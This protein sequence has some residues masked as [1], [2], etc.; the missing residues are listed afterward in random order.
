MKRLFAF[1]LAFITSNLIMSQ[2][3]RLIT[4]TYT[5]GDSKG[6]YVLKFNPKTAAITPLSVT[7]GVENPSYLAISKN[8]QFV[9]AVNENGGDK[10]GEVSAFS[11]NKKTGT[12][13]FINK[14][15]TSGDHPCYVSIDNSG[16]WVFAANYSGGNF[17][18][19]PVNADGSLGKA[20]QVVDDN[21]LNTDAKLKAHVHSTIFTPD[22]KFLL[23]PDLGL[24]KIFIYKFDATAAMPLSPADQ[25]F[26]SFTAGHGPRHVSFHPRLPF[27]Y[28]ISENSGTVSSYTYKDGKFKE[29]D[30]KSN[31]LKTTVPDYLVRKNTLEEWINRANQILSSKFSEGHLLTADE[32]EKLLTAEDETK[33]IVRTAEIVDMYEKFW[34]RRK[35]YFHSRGKMDSL[36][37]CTSMKHLLYDYQHHKGLPIKIK[38][39]DKFFL[40]DLLNWMR[41][42]RPKQL[43]GY[44]YKTR[45]GLNPKTCKKRFDVLL[46]FFG[47]LKDMKI[48][49]AELLDLTRKFMTREIRVVAAHKV[50]LSIQEVHQLYQYDFPNQRLNNIRDL[51]VFACFTGMRWADIE[52]FDAKFI[53]TTPDGKG[54]IYKRM[55]IKTR[56]QSGAVYEIPLCN[57]VLQILERHGNSIKPILLSNVHAN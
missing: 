1:A 33:E 19:F 38:E 10:P 8:E 55:A 41:Q 31:F 22:Q 36:K 13:T 37:D 23:V 40:E 52:K 35:A 46:Q 16:K 4:G 6:I 29:W 3:Y 32:L 17:A 57:T 28:C 44:T 26:I 5:N 14:Q 54:K 48:V 53:R 42:M 7:T 51:F 30:Y 47:F 24:E 27:M 21:K 25:P 20:T 12:L 18:V 56:D 11:F 45:G 34:E 2:D 15:K 9:Y 39:V 49:D 50:T 43:N